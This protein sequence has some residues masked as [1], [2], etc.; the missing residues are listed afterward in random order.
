LKASRHLQYALE[1]QL[2]YVGRANLKDLEKLKAELQSDLYTLGAL[3][4]HKIE[5]IETEE[6][7]ERDKYLSIRRNGKEIAEGS[8]RIE[9]ITA[10]LESV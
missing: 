7:E 3:I 4:D 8:T 5:M 9:A 1:H 10:F 2:K 6:T